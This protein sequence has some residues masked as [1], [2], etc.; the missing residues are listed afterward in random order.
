MPLQALVNINISA[1]SAKVFT[2][3]LV[4]FNLNEGQFKTA[5]KKPHDGGFFDKGWITTM[6]RK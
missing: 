2:F 4:N 6:E 5:I 1:M 3:M